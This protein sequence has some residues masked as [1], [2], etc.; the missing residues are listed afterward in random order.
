MTPTKALIAASGLSQREVAAICSVSQH[1]VKSW[2]VGRLKTPESVVGMLSDVVL[3][4]LLAA[5]HI[6]A[7]GPSE[8]H[9]AIIVGLS[10]AMTAHPDMFPSPEA[11]P[12]SIAPI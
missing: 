5:S 9:R 10:I 6:A 7:G 8:G 12:P 3:Y 4:N 2:S 11:P 1:T